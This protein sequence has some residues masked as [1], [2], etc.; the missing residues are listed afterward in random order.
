MA[1]VLPKKQPE[2]ETKF[3]RSRHS[4]RIRE[5]AAAS[6]GQQ[7]QKRRTAD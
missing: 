2:G 6:T 4:E 3:R 1:S 5:L 7:K